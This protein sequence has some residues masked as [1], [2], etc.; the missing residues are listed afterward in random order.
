MLT[1]TTLPPEHHH[2]PDKW[3]NND[4]HHS[5][6]D[7]Q[8]KQKMH[9][10]LGGKAFIT[11]PLESS[12]MH[13]D[14]VDHLDAHGYAIKSGSYTTAT[15]I[16]NN[17]NPSKRKVIEA[18]IESILNKTKA[19][20]D[21]IS[22][23]SK[24]KR[25]KSLE[26]SNPN[27][28]HVV[29]STTPYA[30]AAASTGTPWDDVSCMRLPKGAWC[31]KLDDDSMNGSHIA[32]LVHGNDVNAFK[33]GEPDA[34]I[35]R[36]LIKPFHVGNGQDRDT[37]FR[38]DPHP[39]GEKNGAFQ[40][41]VTRW[42]TNNYPGIPGKTY[43]KNKDVYPE[44]DAPTT[45]KEYGDSDIQKMIDDKFTLPDVPKYNENYITSYDLNSRHINMALEGTQ[46]HFQNIDNNTM[47]GS[48][49]DRSK[50]IVLSNLIRNVN[51]FNTRHIGK[52]MVLADTTN[53]P[54]EIYRDIAT[55]HGGLFNTN[56]I[57]K[58]KRATN[59][60]AN[61]FPNKLL[62]SPTLSNDD[63][64]SLKP[65]K[66]LY[67]RRSLL[68]QHHID[69]IAYN[70]NDTA[71]FINDF[72]DMIDNNTLNNMVNQHVSNTHHDNFTRNLFLEFATN[73]PE[74]SKHMHDK[75]VHKYTGNEK[76]YRE[77]MEYLLEHSKHASEKDVR[78]SPTMY[79]IR[80]FTS[81]ENIED[82]QEYHN[83]KRII[84]KA[85]YAIPAYIGKKI[86]DTMNNDEHSKLTDHLLNDGKGFVTLRDPNASNKQLDA[87]ERRIDSEHDNLAYADHASLHDDREKLNDH[88]DTYT[89][90]LDNH[91]AEHGITN[92]F[93]VIDPSEVRHGIDRLLDIQEKYRNH[94][95]DDNMDKIRDNI[96]SYRD[97]LRGQ[98]EE[99]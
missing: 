29:I 79:N 52:L 32:Y 67:V 90:F 49:K 83:M 12:S 24:Y 11:F 65:E 74:F 87:M 71:H 48:D 7:D 56:Q 41:A 21:I 6:V 97:K 38:P 66:L 4:T 94:L 98:G 59:D 51:G 99:E 30:I 42:S 17:D 10:A 62:S 73:H 37:I 72:T 68:K 84:L 81:N 53:N 91:V 55:Y 64:D 45:Y 63:V 14:I 43:R 15:K 39:Y 8:T 96:S 35:S 19:H 36:I 82:P 28:L 16:I 89:D 70:F 61:N 80:A 93:Q 23:Y 86:T 78:K 92:S 57:E 27:K 33:H 31:H 69:K 77:N 20:P 95:N 5:L 18:P 88:I 60:D 3:I 13:P 54:A 58:Y 44:I 34:P 9:S 26:T 76:T 47:L 50:R 2:V 1:E 40:S 75:L 46:K 22:A 85:S 25:E